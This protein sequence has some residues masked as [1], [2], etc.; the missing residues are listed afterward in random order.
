LW[1][2]IHAA[3]SWNQPDLIELLCEYG[4]DINAK[5]GAGE[6]PLG[7]WYFFS[8]INLKKIFRENISTARQVSP[9]VLLEYKFLE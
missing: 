2:P 8:F 9:S 4:A 7:L 1:Q 6:S 5:T 3:A